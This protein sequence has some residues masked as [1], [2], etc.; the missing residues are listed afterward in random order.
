MDLNQTLYLRQYTACAVGCV[1]EILRFDSERGGQTIVTSKLSTL[2]L[3]STWP[4][5]WVLGTFSVGVKWLGHE[6]DHALPSAAE[7]KKELSNMSPPPC[8]F[9]ACAVMAINTVNS[10]ELH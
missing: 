5:G 9:M 3:R 8:A 6:A 7:V 4:V 10:S 2:A 1:P